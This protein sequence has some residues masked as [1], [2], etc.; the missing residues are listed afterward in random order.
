[1]YE[2]LYQPVSLTFTDWIANDVSL[3]S[4]LVE[5]RS[6][7]LVPFRITQE[8]FWGFCCPDV[9]FTGHLRVAFALGAAFTALRD[10]QSKRR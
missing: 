6:T 3:I 8:M 10:L 9:M 5:L 4:A 7:V 1:M 2:H